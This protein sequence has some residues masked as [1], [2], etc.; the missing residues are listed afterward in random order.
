MNFD[1]PECGQF[2][3]LYKKMHKLSTECRKVGK[4]PFATGKILGYTFRMFQEVDD[5]NGK[6][7]HDKYIAY[8]CI[9]DET[10]M[11]HQWP[12]FYDPEDIQQWY[13]RKINGKSNN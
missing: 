10:S 2:V 4:Q 7:L 5:P 1:E 8:V 6:S 3:E 12:A 9:N 11:K 13:N